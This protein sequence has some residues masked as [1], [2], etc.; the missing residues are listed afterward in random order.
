[1][2]RHD[3]FTS[4]STHKRKRRQR[5][6][7][8]GLGRRHE[9]LQDS[10]T[11]SSS[12]S[13]NSIPQALGHICNDR[14]LAELSD[15]EGAVGNEVVIGKRDDEE[16]EDEHAYHSPNDDP[17]SAGEDQLDASGALSDNCGQEDLDAAE[18]TGGSEPDSRDHAEVIPEHDYLEQRGID[19]LRRVRN[20]GI[21]NMADFEREMVTVQTEFSMS[22]QA[23]DRIFN[24]LQ[25]NAAI[26]AHGLRHWSRCF[27]TARRDALRLIPPCDV[28]V[29]C[30][31]SS[32][33][34]EVT[35]GP[36]D[37]F[38]QKIIKTRGLTQNFA[39]YQCRLRDIL[40]YHLRLHAEDEIGCSTTLAFDLALDGIPE[41]NSGGVSID[42]LAV[43]FVGCRSVYGL[44]VLRPTRTGM[45]IS[46]AVILERVQDEYEVLR[47]ACPMGRRQTCAWVCS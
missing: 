4:F 14:R 3:P 40:S 8:Q 21:E 15:V 22:K 2:Q 47:H 42:V 31:D 45:G 37:A 12:S 11:S 1:M 23:C 24:I 17:P 41:S 32:T 10:T 25:S 19:V 46:D 7:R 43:R 44:A 9:A 20:R 18:G 34:Q 38:P 33:S 26:I 39:L 16:Q 27:R 29:H 5:Y 6:R 30:L 35:L 36:F 28:T 13:T